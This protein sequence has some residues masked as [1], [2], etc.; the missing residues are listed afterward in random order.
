MFE[1][2]SPDGTALPENE[3]IKLAKDSFMDLDTYV[4]NNKLSIG[5]VKKKKV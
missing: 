5:P 1:Y 4:K 2:I 3:V